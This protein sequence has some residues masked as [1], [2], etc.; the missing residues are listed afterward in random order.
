MN[1]IK[2]FELNPIRSTESDS[3]SQ[4]IYTAFSNP[5]AGYNAN[6]VTNLASLCLT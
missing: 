5:P 2:K 1:C 4:S 3:V 6:T